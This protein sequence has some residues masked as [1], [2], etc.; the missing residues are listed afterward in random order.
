MWREIETIL[1]CMVQFSE[2]STSRKIHRE[3]S[4]PS[5][6]DV[7][8]YVCLLLNS[9]PSKQLSMQLSKASI[10]KSDTDFHKITLTRLWIWPESIS[11]HVEVS[12]RKHS[13][14]TTETLLRNGGAVLAHGM[15]LSAAKK[16]QTWSETWDSK[17]TR[18]PM[19]KLFLYVQSE[20]KS[21]GR[22]I[23]LR[24]FWLDSYYIPQ[25]I[26]RMKDIWTYCTVLP[27]HKV[28][29]SNLLFFKHCTIH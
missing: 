11:Y 14:K 25:H 6:S 2:R 1:L 3:E 26:N 4:A 21:P 8:F 13:S 23:K 29:K 24:M 20:Q 18:N 15:L 28:D 16:T 7:C 9:R 5:P 12:Y 10:Y 27:S 19:L 22:Q 17:K